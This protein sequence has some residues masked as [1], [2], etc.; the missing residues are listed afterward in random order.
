VIGI[1]WIYNNNIFSKKIELN[2]GIEYGNFLTDDFSHYEVWEEIKNTNKQLFYFE[3]EEIPRG[4]V[5]YDLINENF[6]IYANSNILRDK[7]LIS[8][9]FKDFKLNNE[10]VTLKNDY[11]YEILS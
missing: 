6:V 11:H 10:K 4:R 2:K 8:L 1:F 9:I 5:V 7:E 3:Y